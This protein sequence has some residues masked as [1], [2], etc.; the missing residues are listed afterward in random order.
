ME[1]PILISQN[2]EIFTLMLN[3]AV[4]FKFIGNHRKISHLQK[5]NQTSGK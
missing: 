3:I 2:F 5:Y 1:F 4:L